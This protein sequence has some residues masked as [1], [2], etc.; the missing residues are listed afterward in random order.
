MMVRFTVLLLAAMLLLVGGATAQE[1]SPSERARLEAEYAQLEKEIAEQQKIIDQ[2]RAVKNT[3]QGDVTALN[4]QIAKAQKEI[5]AKNNQIKQLG[6]QISTKTQV[7]GE[8]NTRLDK[9]KQSLA[10]MLQQ[11]RELDEYSLVEIALGAKDLSSFFAD[12]D[13]FIAIKQEMSV[14]FSDIQSTKSQTEEER[15]ALAKTQNAVTDARYEV[16][17]KK[18]QV[19]EDKNK[20]QVLLNITANQEAE[21]QRVRAA[22]QAKAAA[23][24]AALFP[25]RDSGPIEFGDAVVYAKAASAKTGVR[26]AMILAVL[27]QESALGTNIGN[28]YV[29]N[30]PAV[31]DGVGKNTGTPF[32]GVMHPTRDV[33]IFMEITAALGKDFK[34]T[35][36]SCPQPGGYGGAMGPTQFIPSTWKLF[37]PRLKAALGVSATNPWNAEHAIMA[38]GLYLGDWSAGAGGYTAERNAA[39]AYFSGKACPASGW[40][41][42]YGDQVMAKA[43]NFQKDIDFLADN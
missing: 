23:I 14:L 1:L 2:T 35:P 39:C 12:V 19:A 16:E 22:N 5:D 32:S 27:S 3:L 8:L 15:A 37:E 36:I 34:T 18:G 41:T 38:T 9:N 42:S 24:R 13:S 10:A 31:G 21:Y 30:S 40:I 11:E 6:S 4:A 33:P 7:I 29:T 25:L 26:P 28:C 17:V 43:A 20:K